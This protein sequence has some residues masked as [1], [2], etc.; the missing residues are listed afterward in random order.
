MAEM[1]IGVTM[2]HFGTESRGRAP[3]TRGMG[4]AIGAA[5]DLYIA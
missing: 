5:A 2:A 4:H 1:L 3:R